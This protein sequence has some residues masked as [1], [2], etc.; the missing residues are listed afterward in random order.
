[1]STV[2]NDRHSEDVGAYLLGALPELEAQI[3]ER[4]VVGCAECRAELERLRPAADAL[5][6]AVDAYEPPPSLKRSLMEEVE[7][8][9]R[10]RGGAEEAPRRR[11]G[12]LFGG[13]L[14]ARPRLAA[15]GAI[16]ALVLGLAVGFGVDRLTRGGG[17][18]TRTVAAQ[19]DRRALPAGAADLVVPSHGAAT[20]RVR[21]LPSLQGGRVYEV[22]L[23]RAGTVRP[24]GAL[25]AV[26][27]D[28]NGAAAI[29]AGL[30][31]VDRVLVTRERAGGAPQPTEPPVISIKT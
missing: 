1:M 12:R 31:G 28:G 19:I 8:D 5:P 22:W 29:P 23:E 14:A 15:A 4:H 3:V 20:L 13:A 25:F 9:V 24:A 10:A 26:A 16:A 27:A 7:R 17:G 2:D 21:G 6:H 30:R 11:R 18:G